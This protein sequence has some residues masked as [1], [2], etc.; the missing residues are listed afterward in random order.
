MANVTIHPTRTMGDTG[1]VRSI[2]DANNNHIGI[3]DGE[4][5]T[6]PLAMVYAFPNTAQIYTSPIAGDPDTAAQEALSGIQHM[7]TGFLLPKSGILTEIHFIAQGN[8]ANLA[9]A[10]NVRWTVASLAN[11]PIAPTGL[12]VGEILGEGVVSIAGNVAG[13]V[14]VVS[15]LSLAVPSQF[16]VFLKQS[17][18]STANEQIRVQNLRSAGPVPGVVGAVSGGSLI[19]TATY[20]AETTNFSNPPGSIP[21]GDALIPAAYKGIACYIKWKGQ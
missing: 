6:I 18:T 8:G 12:A 2:H 17:F 10:R 5:E 7:G 4:E 3:T 14:T 1:I 20:M 16:M 9:T 15:G 21:V 13:D 11:D 19:A